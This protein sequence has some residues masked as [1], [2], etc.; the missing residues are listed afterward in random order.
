MPPPTPVPSVIT[1]AFLYFPPNPAFTSPSAAQFASL[2]IYTS[3]PVAFSIS[4]LRCTSDHLRLFEYT[5]TPFSGFI[6]PGQ[7]I[8]IYLQL[9]LLIPLFSKIFSIE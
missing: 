8:P 2:L 9:F 6:V 7:P 1:T 4:S 5:T 3:N